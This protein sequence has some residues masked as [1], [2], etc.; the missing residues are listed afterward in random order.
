VLATQQA[1]RGHIRSFARDLAKVTKTLKGSDS[2]LRDIFGEG[3]KTAD[4]LND[5]VKQLRP[6]LAPFLSNLIGLNQIINPRLDGIGEIFA[7]LPTTI[8][9]GLFYGTPGDGYGHVSMTYDYTKPPCTIGYLPP[10][11]WPSPHDTR[12]QPL[13]PAR[14]ADPRAQRD[15]TGDDPINQRGVNFAPIVDDSAPIYTQ[16]PYRSSSTS[17]STS[18]STS[19]A[20]SGATGLSSVVGQ[21]GWEGM[22]T[23]E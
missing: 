2:D 7:V 15:Y 9:N 16:N 3:A 8:K 5:L 10:D 1:E 20:T 13:Y 14:C 17:T 4:E 12:E 22:F 23:G 18:S 19:S 21:S 6:V 11:Q